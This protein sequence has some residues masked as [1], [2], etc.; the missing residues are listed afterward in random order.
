VDPF[1][2]DR[3]GSAALAWL[4]AGRFR[5]GF[6]GHGRERFFNVAGP[7]GDPDCDLLVNNERLARCLGCRGHHSRVRGLEETLVISERTARRTGSGRSGPVVGIHP[8]GRYP[9][10]RWPVE[11]YFSTARE[12]L[13]RGV[14]TVIFFNRSM[15]KPAPGPGGRVPEGLVLLESLDLMR[16]VKRLGDV[17]FLLCNNSGPLHIARALGV[18]T[19]SLTGPTRE[20]FVPRGEARHAVLERE[21]VCRPCDKALCWHHSCLS[22]IG[23]DEVVKSIMAMLE[24]DGLRDGRVAG[25]GGNR[26]EAQ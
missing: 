10:Q 24:S 21:L 8:G 14:G 12:L 3:P 19:V 1:V 16:F 26:M 5:C 7:V 6:G 15:V 20:A 9:T 23:V 22:D 4:T 13:A 17:D 2:T 11:R 25:L 18:P